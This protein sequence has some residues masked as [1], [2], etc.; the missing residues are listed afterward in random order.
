MARHDTTRL[1]QHDSIVNQL[2]LITGLYESSRFMSHHDSRVM[3]IHESSRLAIH[4]DFMNSWRVMKTHDRG[5][6]SWWFMRHHERMSQDDSWFMNLRW[7]TSQNPS[8]HGRPAAV[9][10]EVTMVALP[11][12]ISGSQ[13]NQD[14]RMENRVSN[15]VPPPFPSFTRM[16]LDVF[17]GGPGQPGEAVRPRGKSKKSKKEKS[18][19]KCT[20]AKHVESACFFAFSNLFDWFWVNSMNP[21]Y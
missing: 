11:S 2:W 21:N 13:G 7:F 15:L 19:E 14:G 4:D 17:F 20:F 6:E 5:Y 12:R 3:V 18:V 16:E 9:P 10:L 1:D 8:L